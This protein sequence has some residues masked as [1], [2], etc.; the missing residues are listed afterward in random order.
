MERDKTTSPVN[1]YTWVWSG[2]PHDGHK[3]FIPLLLT[4]EQLSAHDLSAEN[5][6][7]SHILA[8]V[9]SDPTASGEPERTVSVLITI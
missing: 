7:S 5:K 1:Q 2:A 4:R 6:I 8:S 9:K 3:T